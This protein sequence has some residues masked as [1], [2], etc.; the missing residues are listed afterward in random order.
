[1]ALEAAGFSVKSVTFDAEKKGQKLLMPLYYLIKLITLVKGDKGQ[2]KY[3]LKDNNHR[4]VC[5]GGN[6]IIMISQKKRL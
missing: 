5:M 3:W 4:N 1:M 2:E 6:S